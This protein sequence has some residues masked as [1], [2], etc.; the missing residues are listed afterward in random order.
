MPAVEAASDFVALL[1]KSKLL[2]PHAF[3]QALNECNLMDMLTPQDVADALV[4]RQM[5]TRYQADRLLNGKRRGY[6]VDEYKIL[7]ILGSGGMG[8]L[9]AA[10]DPETNFQVALKILSER[11]RND[12]GMISRFQLEAEAGLKLNHPNILRTRAIRRT[13]DIYGTI[14]YMVM[15]LVKGVSLY[16]LLAIRR[17]TL[18]WQ[19]ASDVIYQAAKGLHY[20]HQK[21][22]VHRDVKPENL[23]IRTDG[24]VKVLDF[25]LAMV[26]GSDAEFSMATI[27][28]QNCL[29]TA[30]YIAPEQSLDSFEVDCRAD[31]YSLGCTFYFLLTGRVPFPCE[32]VSEKLKSHRTLQPRPVT[33]FRPK[34]PECVNKIILKMMAK[35]P[36][37]RF[38]SAEEVCRFLEPLRQ[39]QEIKFDFD[40]VLAKRAEIA[41]RRQEAESKLRNE[42]RV[43]SV[44]SFD[45]SKSSLLKK[46]DV[47]TVIQKD[48]Q[49]K[50]PTG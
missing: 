23:L 33:E 28:G 36:E 37:M 8:Y 42:S 16:E 4:A 29:G 9:Y 31:I 48:T 46:P 25:G 35:K 18:P 7:E 43:S 12:K 14:Y 41:R 15:E 26:G 3:D 38:Q 11:F 22:L 34:L 50:P 13:E 24:A 21:G 19:Q 40:S 10:E 20:A 27:M 1:K 5:L 6:F 44:T 17:K 45:P 39:R 2:P 30:D 49:L 32:S 47:D